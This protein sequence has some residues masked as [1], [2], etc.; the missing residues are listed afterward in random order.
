MK[1]EVGSYALSYVF[2]RHIN[3][4]RERFVPVAKLLVNVACALCSA[5]IFKVAIAAKP[6][7]HAPLLSKTDLYG[8]A[9]PPNALLRLGTLRLH[10][11]S[12]VNAAA[13]SRDGSMLAAAA[14]M[15]A[16]IVLW[17]IPS[18]RMLR[19]LTGPSRGEF[20]PSTN[21][22]TF[23][24]DGKELLTGNTLGTVCLWGVATGEEVCSIA[25]HS[26][27]P[28]LDGVTAVAF[29]ADGEW[30]ASGGTDGVVRVWST[31]GGHELLSFDTP[32]QP[33]EAFRGAGPS[34]NAVG[35]PGNIAAVAFSPDGKFLAAGIARCPFQSK[36]GKILIWDLNSNQPVR[37][38]DESNGEL[39]SLFY[40]PDGK[41]LISGGNVA[42]PLEKYGRPYR[43]INPCV[44]QVRVWDA[45]TGKMASELA[46]PERE[47]G[48]GAIALSKDG[49]T[50]AVHFEDRMLVWDVP[51]RIIKGSISVPKWYVDRGL[52]TSD[53]GQVVCAPLDSTLGV[54][55]TA[56]GDS[57]LQGA[58]SHTSY[59]SMV[60]YAHDGSF[61]ATCGDGTIRVWKAATG[62]QQ[63]ARQFGGEVAYVNVIAVSP[64][65]ALIAAGGQTQEGEGGVRILRSATGEEVR[66]IPIFET[67]F[68]VDGLV[69]SLDSTKLA[70]ARG[71]PKAANTFDI[72][73]YDVNSGKKG[74]EIASA[75]F[76]GVCTM[77]FSQDAELLYTIDGSN[78]ADVGIWDTATGQ[79]RRQ[80]TALKP[81]P[82]PAGGK[83]EKPW[84]ADAEFA[85]DL[86]TLVTS[87]NRELVVWDLARGEPITTVPT[88]GTDKGGRIALSHDGRLLAM[89]DLLFSG[90]AGSDAIHV[91]DL[92]SRRE[93]ATFEPGQG[94]AS[95]FAFS[96]D[97][98]RLVTGMSDGTALVWDLT[99]AALK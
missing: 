23:S 79:R 5:N 18:G 2:H 59:I 35:P 94:R 33:Q 90:D 24:P 57:L 45:A 6:A 72:D 84:I 40:T 92:K 3:M 96:P 16:D 95:T 64:D 28:E 60:D 86:K 58:E 53:D 66:F 42:I 49:S 99:A 44:P 4:R 63:W 68:Y 37:W 77:A 9:L 87:Q 70:I 15:D 7:T 80:F 26:G 54:W 19:R 97:G 61:I 13:F 85:R 11:Q 43:A 36:T 67:R 98:R 12:F 27:R 65:G 71:R 69:F 82:K 88:R 38:I 22:L 14:V 56:T 30:F 46:A 78:K 73:V 41:H 89:S 91:W 51:S 62:R 52:A 76:L 29:S 39:V 17:E 34:G 31:H 83:Q 1:D 81:P 74:I 10:H 8:D 55:N 32:P 20:W 75:N 21:A 93:V 47:A 50:L 48:S 25:A